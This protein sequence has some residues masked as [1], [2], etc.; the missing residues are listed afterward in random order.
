MVWV[1]FICSAQHLSLPSLMPLTCDRIVI[2]NE[3][4]FKISEYIEMTQLIP[5]SSNFM[6]RLRIADEI[7]KLAEYVFAIQSFVRL[8]A[9]NKKESN[10][11]L[12][13][14]LV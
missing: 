13:F 1:H 6:V 5:N 3:N 11:L 2:G 10:A 14:E 4:Y 8:T 9:M 7:Q 12:L